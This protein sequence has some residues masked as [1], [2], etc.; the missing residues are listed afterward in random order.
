VGSIDLLAVAASVV[1]FIAA[2]LLVRRDYRAGDTLAGVTV[3]VVWAAYLLHAAVTTW[4][5]CTAPL[6]RMAMPRIPALAVGG[7]LAVAGV[8][9][10]GV[11]IANFRSFERMSGLDTSRLIHRGIYGRSRNPQNLGW[12]LALLGT[13]VAGRSPAALGLVLLF[14]LVIHLYIVTL[15]EPYLESV[16]GDEFRDYRRRVRRYL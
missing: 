11:A 9:A 2:L 14:A 1:F 16:Y 15:E 10:A 6:G 12:G 8:T 13:A 5:A 7:L 3:V 4:L